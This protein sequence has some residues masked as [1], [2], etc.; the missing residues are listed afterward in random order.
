MTERE[1]SSMRK[2]E[3][4]AEEKKT[5]LWASWLS[6]SALSQLVRSSKEASR[7]GRSYSMKLKMKAI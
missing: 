3:E 6:S 2:T 1:M 4:A 7:R 5:N